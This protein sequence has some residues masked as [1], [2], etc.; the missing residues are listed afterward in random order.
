RKKEAAAEPSPADSGAQPTPAAPLATPG[1]TLYGAFD[2]PPSL[3]GVHSHSFAM[4][5]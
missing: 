2:G 3:L 5:I 4:P 1:T